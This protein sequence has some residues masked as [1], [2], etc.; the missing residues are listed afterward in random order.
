MAKAKG[1]GDRGSSVQPRLLNVPKHPGAFGESTFEVLDYDP[2]DSEA[3][4]KNLSMA[5]ATLNAIVFAHTSRP[6]ERG[7]IVKGRITGSNPMQY[8]FEEAG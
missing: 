4:L 2:D 8:R 7:E 1:F 5:G 6:M 3:T